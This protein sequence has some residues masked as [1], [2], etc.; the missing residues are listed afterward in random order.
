MA[1]SFP[2]GRLLLGVTGS[3]H[4]VQLPQYMMRFKKTFATDIRIM[5]TAAAVRMCPPH[6]LE[7]LSEHRVETDL[8]GSPELK[9][10][11]IRATDWADLFL[12]LPAT[13]NILAKAA[14]GIADDLVTTAVAAARDPVVF[15]PAMNPSMWRRAATQRNVDQLRADGHYIIPPE[16]IVSMTTG[17]FDEG[18]GPTPETLLPHLW[19]VC[20]RQRQR[21]Y[22]PI[23]TA[24]PPRSP[25]QAPPRRTLALSSKGR[26]GKPLGITPAERADQPDSRTSV[27]AS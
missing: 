18:L 23:A 16:T 24:E 9:A 25:S 15:A 17:R 21:S 22:W 20:M 2:C 27:G 12:V 14:H 19:H 8:W 1:G 7:L 13:A 5:M 11:H 4:C 26:T 10:P 3:I 6:V